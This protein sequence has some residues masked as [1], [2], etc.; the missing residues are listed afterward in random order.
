MKALYGGAYWQ[1]GKH[2]WTFIGSSVTSLGITVWN[3]PGLD[4]ASWGNTDMENIKMRSRFSIFELINIYFRLITKAS[5]YLLALLNYIW[6]S[7]F[8]FLNFAKLI[9]ICLFAF[10]V[11]PWHCDVQDYWLTRNVS[12]C[13]TPWLHWV[14]TKIIRDLCLSKSWRH[15]LFGCD[16]WAR[17]STSVH[18]I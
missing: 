11:I 9:Q 3:R 7:F 2:G 1:T 8:F 10:Q 17:T 13:L 18:F 5:F 15:V 6:S 12:L 14:Q 16:I 4:P